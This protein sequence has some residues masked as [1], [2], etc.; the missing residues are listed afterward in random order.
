LELH[1]QHF[2]LPH[3]TTQPHHSLT[4]STSLIIPSQPHH[5][6]HS[7]FISQHN[8]ITTQTHHP[9]TPSTS[10]HKLIIPSQPHHSSHSLFTSQHNHITTQTQHSS[11]PQLHY[12]NLSS[13]LSTITHPT[14]SSPPNTITSPHKYIIN[15]PPQPH[16]TNLSSHLSHTTHPTHSSQSHHHT[17]TTFSSSTQPHYTNLSSHLSPTTHP[18]HSSP[19]NTIT[20]PHKHNIP[21]FHLNRA[22]KSP[23]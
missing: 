9:L 11:F 2:H 13:H 14:Y 23:I 7:L 6:S 22:L 20:S 19:P 1:A 12:T 15:S 5:P 8:H 21:Q 18:T 17:N 10:L 16:Y 3:I 4:P